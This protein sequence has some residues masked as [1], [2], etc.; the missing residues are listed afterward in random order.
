MGQK[1][2]IMWSDGSTYKCELEHIH[3]KNLLDLACVIGIKIIKK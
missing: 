2:I 1:Y 3:I